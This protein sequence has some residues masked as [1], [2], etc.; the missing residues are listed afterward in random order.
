MIAYDA[1][2]RSSHWRMAIERRSLISWSGILQAYAPLV[3]YIGPFDGDHARSR[4][5]S[6][7]YTLPEPHP[8][9]NRREDLVVSV[10][11]ELLERGADNP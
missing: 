8:A 11:V 6:Y 10:V 4:S 3:Q 2:R 1:S 9:N 5:S 7:S